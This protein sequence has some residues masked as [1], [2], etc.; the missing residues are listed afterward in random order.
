MSR[1]GACLC[2]APS[3]FLEAAATQLRAGPSRESPPCSVRT[4]GELSFGS[5]A[6][7]KSHGNVDVA[8]FSRPSREALLMALDLSALLL[9]F[10]HDGTWRMCAD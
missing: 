10:M 1:S 4:Q 9:Q 7:D 6:I 5:S 8:I 2:L 3:C